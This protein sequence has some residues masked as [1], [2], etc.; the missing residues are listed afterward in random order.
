M[1][2]QKPELRKN[3]I[4]RKSEWL[5]AYAFIAPTMIGLI[6][7]NLYPMIKTISL[8]MFQSMGL[9]PAKYVGWDNYVKMFST[10]MTWQATWNTIRFMLM[11]VPVGVAI[12][13]V[14]ASLLNRNIKGRDVYRGIY[15]LPTIVTPVAIALVWQWL[16]NGELGLINQFL[17][18]FGI[19]GPY[20]LSNPSTALLS[21]SIIT[22][23]GSVGYDLVLLLSGLQSI[24]RHYYEASEID[25]ASHFK[26]FF[27]ITLPMITPTLFFVFLVR[28]M[29]A[30]KVFDTIYLLMKTNNPAYRSAV[31][32]MPLF[33]REGYET[34]N[35][36]YASA[37]VM[38][39]F[40]IIMFFTLIQLLGEKKLVNYD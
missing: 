13:L 38:W 31:T 24:S 23:W 34:F 36:G 9:G 12:A 4:D 16:F 39:T 33:Y 37:I 30:L 3:R 10:P 5:W 17:K 21:C 26:Q 19:Q 40:V 18:I 27:H 7:L 6:I 25:G 22:V 2:K 20:W 28:L 14:L 8:S 32:L 11:T 35:K 29:N 15:F 1:F